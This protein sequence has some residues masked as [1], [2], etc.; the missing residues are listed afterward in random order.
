MTDN[1]STGYVELPE[2]KIHYY[3]AGG[4]K[5]PL[6]LSHGFTDN[7]LC[8]TPLARKLSA[9]YDVIMYDT[10]GHGLSDCVIPQGDIFQ[11]LA[12]D[13]AGLIQAL[14]LEKPRIIGHSLGAATAAVAAA[15]YPELVRCAVLE[16][17]PWRASE[18][19]ETGQER[20]A[21]MQQWHTDAVSHQTKRPQDL[22]ALCRS[23]HPR[24]SEDECQ[25]WANSKL[26]LN[27]R[28]FEFFDTPPGPW[29]DVVRRIAC[30][31]LLVTGDPELGAIVT[32]EIAEESVSICNDIQVTHLP[33]AGHN[34]R[35]EQFGPYVE[36]VTAFLART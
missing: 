34:I 20:R 4:D 23:Q 35:R 22:V 31:V 2:L 36:Q 19:G 29:Q 13:L 30:P 6:V 16:D 18:A 26:Q 33:G 17:P 27:L 5:S 32:P 3:R 24:W 1:W 25:P 21:A 10:R 7:G 15:N 12:A 9:D 11:H 28:I 8:W 14:K